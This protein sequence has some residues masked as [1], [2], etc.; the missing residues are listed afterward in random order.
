MSQV[1][2]F[3]VEGTIAGVEKGP[4][5]SYQS[6]CAQLLMDPGQVECILIYPCWILPISKHTH[7]SLQNQEGAVV[8][9]VVLFLEWI[10]VPLEALHVKG[11]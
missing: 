4:F 2:N 11:V 3:L 6:A 9:S 5:D 1:S 7:C 10:K 8:F